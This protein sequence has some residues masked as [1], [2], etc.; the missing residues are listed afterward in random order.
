MIHL[1]GSRASQGSRTAQEAESRADWVAWIKY[2]QF[3]A[4]HNEFDRARSVFERAL[5][6]DSRQPD[7][8]VS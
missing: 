5:E 4:S 7:V 6:V 2:A 1:K 3:E 8:W